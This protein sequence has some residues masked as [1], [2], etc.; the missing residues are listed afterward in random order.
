MSSQLA[1]FA[2]PGDIDT[3]TGGFIYERSLLN[4]LRSAGREVEHIGLAASY[5]DP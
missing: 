5:P 1:A 3:R 2:I 4:A